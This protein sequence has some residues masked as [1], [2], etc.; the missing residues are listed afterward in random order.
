MRRALALSLLPLPLLAA[1]L[2]MPS[3]ATLAFEGVVTN[4][5]YAMPVGPWLEGEIPKLTRDGEVRQQAWRIDA[6]G[7][8]TAQ[9]LGPL[10]DQL[11]ADGF[12]IAFECTDDV[13]GGF[14]FRF[15]TDVIP[16]PDMYVDLGDYRYMAFQTETELISLLASRTSS[17]GFIQIM[18]VGAAG[19]GTVAEVDAPALRPTSVALTGDLATELETVGRVILGD[20]TFETG[21]AQLGDQQF[22]SLAALADYLRANPSR[23]VALVGHTDAVGSLDGNIALS[24]RRAGSVLERLVSTY[25]IP[26]RQLAAEG[27]GYLSP[28]A[29]NVTEEGR[30]ANRRVEVIIT[31]TE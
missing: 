6:S 2:D 27:M 12:E 17:T 31:S 20:L 13:C 29:T 8:T 14:D 23:T 4:D 16:A 3:N 25:D 7:L 5:S 19:E 1:P 26:R 22:A 24:K 9:M 18:R 11:T 30:D 21:S 15:G 10:R 28:I